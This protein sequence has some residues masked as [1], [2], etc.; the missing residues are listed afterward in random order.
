MAETTNIAG[1]NRLF[2][3]YRANPCDATKWALMAGLVRLAANHQ[4]PQAMA[5]AIL[6]APLGVK[7]THVQ[8]V[9]AAGNAGL[10][11]EDGEGGGNTPE[12]P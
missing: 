11:L 6:I 9:A 10:R 7:D 12:D 3:K 8:L 5:L 1:I 2:K 4:K